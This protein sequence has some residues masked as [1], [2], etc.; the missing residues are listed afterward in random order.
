MHINISTSPVGNN[1]GSVAALVTYLEKE[2]QGKAAHEKTAFFSHDKDVVSKH[3]VI[4]SM[5][6]NRKGLKTKD[7]KF[8]HITIAPSHNE[9]AHINNDSTVLRE[10]T[11]QVMDAYAKN[12][13]RGITGND[14]MYFAKIEQERH[15]DNG[16]VKQGFN[17]HI[18]VIVARKDKRGERQFSPLTNHRS[19]SKGAV[20]GGFYRKA[21]QMKSEELFDALTKYQ[22]PLQ[23]SFRYFD[24]Q[25]NGTSKEQFQLKHMLGTTTLGKLLKQMKEP[26]EREP[27]RRDLER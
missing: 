16:S 19:T 7:A 12:F 5:D 4:T 26:P 3:G 21:W 6:N 2:N 11:R 18:H 25:K 8:Y 20:R 24:I 1:R 22:R 17:T 23:E 27:R 14:L 13:K 10:Y 15:H 9:L